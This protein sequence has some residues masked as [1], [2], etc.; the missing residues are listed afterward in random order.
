MSGMFVS[1][2]LS[3][4]YSSD[5]YYDILI[6]ISEGLGSDSK[7]NKKFISYRFILSN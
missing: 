5:G 4:N 3:I 2:S 7:Q 6:Q 1:I